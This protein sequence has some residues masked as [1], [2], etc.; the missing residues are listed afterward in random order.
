M[1]PN[2]IAITYTIYIIFYETLIIGGCGYI[3]FGLHHSLWWWAL[4]VYMSASACDPAKW[5]R[6]LTGKDDE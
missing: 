3:T 2:I 6:L 4:A 1:K 5:N